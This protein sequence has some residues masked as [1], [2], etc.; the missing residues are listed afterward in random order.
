MP[1]PTLGDTAAVLGSSLSGA[2]PWDMSYNNT[3]ALTLI[4]P[5][6]LDFTATPPGT[7][8]LQLLGDG[9]GNYTVNFIGGANNWAQVGPVTCTYDDLVA[10]IYKTV[11]TASSFADVYIVVYPAAPPPPPPSTK[12]PPPTARQS[13]TRMPRTQTGLL[14]YAQGIYNQV[15][16]PALDAANIIFAAALETARSPST[17]TAVTINAA[18]VAEANVRASVRGVLLPLAPGLAIPGIIPGA[19]RPVAFKGI[20]LKGLFVVFETPS[21]KPLG[22]QGAWFRME[23][24]VRDTEEIFQER[25]WTKFPVSIEVTPTMYGNAIEWRGRWEWLGINNEFPHTPWSQWTLVHM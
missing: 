12:V 19:A 16:G 10:G 18:Q 24:R 13:L 11:N 21:G 23:Y 4:G 17:R 20:K 22:N 9:A 2:I 8:T 15:G 7:E 14:S 6:D 3:Y 1:T 5:L 25:A